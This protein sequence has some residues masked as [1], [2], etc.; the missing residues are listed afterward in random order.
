MPG[1]KPPPKEEQPFSI[2]MPPE[3]LERAA[4]RAA[5]MRKR[6]YSSLNTSGTSACGLL[7]STIGGTITRLR[8]LIS[9]V[10]GGLLFVATAII[11]LALALQACLAHRLHLAAHCTRPGDGKCPPYLMVDCPSALTFFLTINH[12]ASALRSSCGSSRSSSC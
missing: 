5:N 10:V 12:L 2:T 1:Y 8:E 7:C 3:V 11:F 9:F 4:E 6:G